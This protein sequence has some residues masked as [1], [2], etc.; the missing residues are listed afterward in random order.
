MSADKGWSVGRGLRFFLLLVP[1]DEDDPFFLDL[2]LL[3]EA[4]AFVGPLIFDFSRRFLL[5]LLL[6]LPRLLFLLFFLGEAG[7]KLPTST[8]AASTVE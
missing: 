3:A 4:L 7:E 2:L 5:A 6:L 1:R 8:S